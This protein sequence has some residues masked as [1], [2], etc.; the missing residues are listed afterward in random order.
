MKLRQAVQV[1]SMPY[2]A[3]D[4]ACWCSRIG[5]PHQGNFATLWKL[6]LP[7]QAIKEGKHRRSRFVLISEYAICTQRR[8]TRVDTTP[9]PPFEDASFIAKKVSICKCEYKE[10]LCWL[11][12]YGLPDDMLMMV[13][14]RLQ[15]RQDPHGVS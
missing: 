3:F 8:H 9:I 4:L 1:V 15:F 12:C 11:C 6:S 14:F 7:S 13:L 10:I 5:G 2:C